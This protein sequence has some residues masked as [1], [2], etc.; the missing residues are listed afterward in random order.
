MDIKWDYLIGGELIAANN[1]LIVSEKHG[2]ISVFQYD[3]TIG[4]K[5]KKGDNYSFL[6]EQNYPNPF[7]PSTSISFSVPEKMHVYLRVF[8][9]L[10][11]QVKVLKDEVMK[12]G[13]Y[14][15]MWNAAG[16][17]SGIYIY[18]LQVNN[19]IISKKLTLLK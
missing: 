15:I 6:L 3:P 13:R 7:N 10:G 19:K 8:N 16:L 4:I 14:E 11:K 17:A 5:E 18:T 1:Y 9:I 2:F 12:K